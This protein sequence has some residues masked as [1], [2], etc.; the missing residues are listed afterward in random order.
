MSQDDD[1][2]SPPA[3]AAMPGGGLLCWTPVVEAATLGTFHDV[4]GDHRRFIDASQDSWRRGLRCAGPPVTLTSSSTVAASAVSP[5]PQQ[6]PHHQHPSAALSSSPPRW[7]LGPCIAS[8]AAGGHCEPFAALFP[9]AATFFLWSERAAGSSN[10]KPL[11]E[12][13]GGGGSIAATSSWWWWPRFLNWGS[14]SPAAPTEPPPTRRQ[15]SRLQ[16]H[17]AP[18]RE[19]SVLWCLGA[20]RPL[21]VYYDVRPGMAV[22]RLGAWHGVVTFSAA[23]D[24]PS[25]REELRELLRLQPPPQ[26]TTTS[27]EGGAPPDGERRHSETSDD[28]LKKGSNSSSR[29]RREEEEAAGGGGKGVAATM[30]RWAAVSLSMNRRYAAVSLVWLTRSRRREGGG[31]TTTPSPTAGGARGTPQW[32]H[33]S[34]TV[35]GEHTT[36]P[37]THRS[38]DGRDPK[39]AEEKAEGSLVEER[40]VAVLKADTSSVSLTLMAGTSLTAMLRWARSLVGK[41]NPRESSRGRGGGGVAAPATALRGVVDEEDPPIRSFLQ[42]GSL[43]DDGGGGASPHRRRPRQRRPVPCYLRFAFGL[44]VRRDPLTR[45]TGQLYA[46][47]GVECGLSTFVVSS[48]FFQRVTATVSTEVPLPTLLQRSSSRRKRTA[49]KGGWR[50]SLAEYDDDDDDDDAPVRR[51]IGVAA[52]LRCNTI[53]VRGTAVDVGFRSLNWFTPRSSCSTDHDDDVVVWGVTSWSANSVR[54]PAQPVASGAALRPLGGGGTVWPRVTVGITLHDAVAEA[55]KLV[56]RATTWIGAVSA[57]RDPDA[58]T[59]FSAH[60]GSGG[61]NVSLSVTY[62]G[63]SATTQRGGRVPLSLSLGVTY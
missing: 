43:I 50:G 20:L 51:S 9:H 55:R 23:S 5:S 6:A 30:R 46:G 48:D 31:A 27:I 44:V 32:S 1:A 18:P 16:G 4:I 62:G 49:P 24:I 3:T 40:Q 39:G 54:L 25:S 33:D 38:D 14:R 45:F 41:G 21:K 26:T 19:G 17:H 56:R 52:R 57:K 34:S 12:G 59:S 22:N 8:A 10:H 47:G 35:G 28:D 13:A 60:D 2:D 42:F 7:I 37:A 29:T 58:A 61:V 53:T 15:T 63:G 36:T 11:Q